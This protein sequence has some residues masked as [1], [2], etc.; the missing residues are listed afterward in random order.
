[1]ADSTKV[2]LVRCP[3]CEN[4]LPELAD[5][6]VYQCGGCGAVLRAKTKNGDTDTSPQMS[7]EAQIAGVT[8]QLQNSLEKQ[9]PE[10][11]DSSDVDIK[12]NDGSLST[13]EKNPRKNCI[14][15]DDADRCR[16]QSNATSGKLVIENDLDM[17]ISG[18]KLGSAV[19]RENG[20][21]NSEIR[22]STRS[23][24]SGKMAGWEHGERGEMERLQGALTNE[25]ESVR[26]STSNYPDEGPSNYNV[27]SSYCHE[28]P[29][30]DHDGHDEATKA[31]HLAKDRAELLRKLDELKEQLSRSYDVADKTKKAPLN[32][33]IAPPGPYV[34]SDTWFPGASSVPDRASMQFF[35]P[36]QH[37]PKPPYFHHQPDPFS[38]NNAH[39]MAMH[40]FH[41][42]VH[43]SNQIPGFGDPFLLKRASHQLS[44]Q[45]QQPSSQ[46]FSRHFFDTNPDPYETY[47]SNATFHQPSCS[48][49][50][51]YERHQGVPSTT[52]C[53]KRFPD[54]SNNPIVYQHEN[55]G[56]FPPPVHNAR[57]SRPPPSDFRGS[58]SNTRWPSDPNSEMG[59]FA[60][61]RPRKVVLA[62]GGRCCRPIVGGA[63]FLTC[64]NCFELLQFPK[65]ALLM[66]K[67]QQK[68]SCGA[69]STVINFSIINRKLVLSF[70]TEMT[71][72]PAE[73]DDSST[74]MLKNNASYSHGRMSRI[75]ANFSSN[76]YDNSGY[77][78]Q[79]VDTD[80]IALLTGQGLNTMKHQEMNG[81]HA[82]SPSASENETSPDALIVPREV[83]N[84]IQQPIKAGL[85]PP[86]SGSPL[87]QHFDYSTS[88][89]VVNRFG[90]GNRSSR[91]DQEK[92]ITSKTTTRQNSMKERSLA[93]EIEV[94]FHEY[95]NTGVSQDSGDANR[96]D[97]QLKIT[98]GGESFFANI[99]KKSFKDFSRSNQR[100][101]R[102]RSNV[103]VNGHP[104]PDRLVKKAEK[105]AGPIH[106]GQYWYD[107]RAGFW[108]AI[109]GPCLGIIPKCQYYCS[110]LL[111]SSII[112]CQK[113]VRVG[114]LVF[115]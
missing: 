107:S 36:D 21:L 40:N 41:P 70:N 52:F 64:F 81:F 84:S 23:W 31:Q 61:Y 33:R 28:G 12:S 114:I 110:L 71:K 9:D 109:G 29:L 92:V 96:E 67:N 44:G 104:I 112:Q 37:A 62:S 54:V 34:G 24:R 7:D 69:C 79:A 85:S 10:L 66:R 1:M 56:A 18:D 39:E 98:K 57:T 82:S 87:Q 2:R 48:C 5:Y 83:V 16:N 111:K 77:D 108:G 8:T 100:D 102:G 25:V 49:F 51:C 80:S 65:K 27:G 103:S 15:D 47:T 58:L 94:P 45:Y 17:D 78:F 13:D 115:L 101:E 20:D 30:R 60:R 95:S 3:K 42:L 50:H 91:S 106:P 97:S 93:T 72:C 6:S 11:S 88:S 19:G 46:Y 86:P 76:D 113:I 73:G 75:N 22:H 90:K 53:N 89:N 43:K 59:G 99:I 105:L 35:A 32:R 14:G 38:Y 55:H 26:F 68:M 74:E 4:L 63:P